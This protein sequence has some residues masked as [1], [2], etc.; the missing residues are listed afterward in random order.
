ML[1]N[2]RLPPRV[3]TFTP[4]SAAHFRAAETSSSVFGKATAEGTG[5]TREF[6]ASVSVF[7]VAVEG[8]EFSTP[9]LSR[10][11][12]M[13]VWVAAAEAKPPW[14]AMIAQRAKIARLVPEIETTMFHLVI[15]LLTL[16]RLRANV[17]VSNARTC[18]CF[19]ATELPDGRAVSLRECEIPSVAYN[20]NDYLSICHWK[21][22][23]VLLGQAFFQQVDTRIVKPG[24]SRCGDATSALIRTPK[25]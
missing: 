17:E 10:H 23:Q 2:E 14:V 7:Q 19:F 25:V 22:H 21:Q 3:V 9:A 15:E 18:S 24:R 5:L 8:N 4:A 16:G 20:Q 13:S 12:P 6:H 11:E 1:E